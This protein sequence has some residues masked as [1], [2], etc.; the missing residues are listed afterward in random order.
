MGAV[1]LF[2][3]GYASLTTISIPFIAIIVFSI[4]AYKG[5][6]P[7]VYVMYGVLAEL[8]LLWALRPNIKRLLNGTE[9][10]IGWRA[11]KGEKH[12]AKIPRHSVSLDT[13]NARTP[14]NTI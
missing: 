5:L 13:E 7:V 4:R 1:I 10:V 14:S 12:T 6:S 2:G 8:I 9:R 3:V 11:K